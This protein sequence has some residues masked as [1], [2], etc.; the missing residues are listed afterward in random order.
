MKSFCLRVIV[1]S[2]TITQYLADAAVTKSSLRGS[3]LKNDPEDNLVNASVTLGSNSQP[4]DSAVNNE[5]ERVLHVNLFDSSEI[6][7]TL[8]AVV[9]KS[10]NK[11]QCDIKYIELDGTVVCETLTRTGKEIIVNGCSRNQE[12]IISPNGKARCRDIPLSRSREIVV[13]HCR[14]DEHLVVNSNGRVRCRKISNTRVVARK[15]PRRNDNRVVVY[16][17]DDITQIVRHNNG[18]SNKVIVVDDDDDSVHVIRRNG[19]GGD[20]VVIIDNDNNRASPD[21]TPVAPPQGSLPWGSDCTNARG[22]CL[23]GLTC[24][25]SPLNGSDR[26]TC[27]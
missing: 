21:V 25:P 16:D 3:N 22:L 4:D 14:N 26:W 9:L 13:D 8:S 17:Q 10:M 1:L 7:V 19:D 2:L 12:L 20:R 6:D 5:R 27:Q 24:R 18:Y 11:N 23:A 15:G